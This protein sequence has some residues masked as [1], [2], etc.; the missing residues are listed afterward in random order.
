LEE[1][2]KSRQE[3]RALISNSMEDLTKK[4]GKKLKKKERAIEKSLTVFGSKRPGEG[5]QSPN[6]I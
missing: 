1:G 5:L 6:S 4:R 2:K 3:L